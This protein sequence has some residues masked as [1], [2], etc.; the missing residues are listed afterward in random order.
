LL[1]PHVFFKNIAGLSHRVA[2]R[3]ATK[4]SPGGLPL[5]LAAWLG[6]QRVESAGEGQA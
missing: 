6:L 2:D 5:R 4:S 3:L 1:M